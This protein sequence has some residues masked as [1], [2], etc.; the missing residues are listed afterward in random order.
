[1]KPIRRVY[2]PGCWDLLHIGHV[3]FLTRAAE[4]GDLYVGVAGDDTIYLDK[5][6]EPIIDVWKRMEL[7]R[8]LKCVEDVYLYGKL[9][10]IPHLEKILP[11][12]LVVGEQWGKGKIK[13]KR[14]KDAE[15]WMAKTGGRVVTIPYCTETSTTDICKR[16][17]ELR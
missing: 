9:D 5:G 10:F 11:N 4:Y 16:V 1:M 3:R 7:V 12:I 2:T 8:A 13:Q 17:K 15:N 6:R 14:H